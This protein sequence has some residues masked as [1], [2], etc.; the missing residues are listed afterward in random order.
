VTATVASVDTAEDGFTVETDAGDRYRTE[1]VVAATK[2][3][4]GY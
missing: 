4:V 1:Y 2:N 3:V